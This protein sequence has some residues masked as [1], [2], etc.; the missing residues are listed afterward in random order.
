MYCIFTNIGRCESSAGTF[1]QQSQNNTNDENEKK[2]KKKK[3]FFPEDFS[4]KW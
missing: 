2:K 3:T 4:L 1:T